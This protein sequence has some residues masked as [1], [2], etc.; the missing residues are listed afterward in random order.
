MWH[1]L[2]AITE[3]PFKFKE[4]ANLLLP[5]SSCIIF[6]TND[7]SVEDFDLNHRNFIQWGISLGE[8]FLIRAKSHA[9][10]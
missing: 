6:A 8:L 7:T 3:G 4:L 1:T 10:P 5:A 2:D 9:K